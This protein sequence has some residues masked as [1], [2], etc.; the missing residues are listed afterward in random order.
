MHHSQSLRE[1]F[2]EGLEPMRIAIETGTH[3]PWVSRLLERLGHQTLVANARKL[4]LIYAE[5]REND[6]L[7]AL[8]TWLVLPGRIR[9]CSLRY[10][11]EARLPRLIWRSSVR[12]RR[13]SKRGP[14]SS[15]MSAGRSSP[16]GLGY[17]S[18]LRPPTRRSLRT[19]RSP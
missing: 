8:R 1:A 3:S 12:A 15:T 5:G 11:T 4:K 18:A 19:C 9:S 16:S 17:P 7:D 14:S 13:S 6:R 10:D 2:L